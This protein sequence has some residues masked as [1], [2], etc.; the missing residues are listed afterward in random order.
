MKKILILSTSNLTTGARFHIDQVIKALTLIQG[1]KTFL[2]INQ[3]FS[4][5]KRHDL[6]IN[7]VKACK[8]KIINFLYILIYIPIYTY[9]KKID[10]T[11]CP[12]GMAPLFFRGKL[13]VGAHNPIL[14]FKIKK[15][16]LTNLFRYIFIKSLKQAH[17]IKVPSKS[18]AIFLAKSFEISYDRFAVIYH[19]VNIQ[20]WKSLISK[21]N[22]T[23]NKYFIFWSWFHETKGIENMIYGFAKFLNKNK[24]NHFQLILAGRFSSNAY[25]NKIYDLIKLLDISSSI[26]FV[27]QP[28]LN[29]LIS[30]IK[31]SSGIILPFKYETFGFPYIESRLFDKPIAVGSNLVSDEITEGQSYTFNTSSYSEIAK[32]FD[33]L[34]SASRASHSYKINKKFYSE[35]EVNELSNLFKRFF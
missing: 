23:E 30:L 8:V 29:Q 2:H 24:G 10:I 22:K 28:P 14:L 17:V 6:E 27:I 3:E 20:E 4:F 11:Y 13:I 19:G 31:N 25:K 15:F 7:N 21:V 16:S 35:R 12:W 1:K 26:N 9:F 34:A 18:Y 33:F 32:A 5:S